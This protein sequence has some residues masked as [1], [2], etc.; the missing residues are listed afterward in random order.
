MGR[1]LVINGLEQ[2]SRFFSRG[3]HLLRAR[4]IDPC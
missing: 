4:V 3:V 2:L 1:M